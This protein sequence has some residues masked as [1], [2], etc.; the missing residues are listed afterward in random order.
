MKYTYIKIL[1]VFFSLNIFAQTEND[2][3][4]F[5]IGGTKIFFVNDTNYTPEEKFKG[6][7]SSLSIGI[8]AFTQ[9]KSN[10]FFP[11]EAMNINI[12]RSWEFNLDFMD[13]SFNLYKKHFG[14][15][16]G[17]GFKF[18][19]YRLSENYKIYNDAKHVY[20][21]IDTTINYSKIKLAINSFRIPL[22]FEWQNTFGRKN[23]QIYISTGG[24]ISYRMA[25]FLKY[26]Y[27]L[28][29]EKRKDKNFA[30]YH[31]NPLQYGILLKIGISEFEIYM[32]Y[33]ISKMFDSNEGIDANQF[34]VG[35]ILLEL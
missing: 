21:E 2:T 14:I 31:I 23:R 12:E 35:L 10:D 9:N 33:N 34:S 17:L 24:F 27:T 6:H 28:N 8:N 25:S 32:E 3:A 18:Q 4:F 13:L 30:D 29:D 20:A 11:V 16:T 7:Y 22:L 5:Q 1:F 19:N 15:V 26:N